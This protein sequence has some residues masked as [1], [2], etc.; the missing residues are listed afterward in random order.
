MLK[1][2]KCECERIPSVHTYLGLIAAESKR[3]KKIEL[4][5]SANKN[6]PFVQEMLNYGTNPDYKYN[7][8]LSELSE[9]EGKEI[10]SVQWTTFIKPLFD[11]LRNREITGNAAKA[12][13]E[14]MAIKYNDDTKQ[15]LLKILNKDFKLGIGRTEF[16]KVF[17]EEQMEKRQFEVALAKG[18]DPN[19]DDIF[20]GDYFLSRKLDGCVSKDSIIEFEN[21]EKKS[22]GEVV[23]KRIQGK[24]KSFDVKNGKIVFSKIK[25]Y[26]I[27]KKENSNKRWF[28]IKTK[29]GKEIK[30]TENDRLF[31][32]DGC[33]VEVSKLG[34]QDS[35]YIEN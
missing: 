16:I 5:K 15:L 25:D 2:A 10:D 21:G 7:I 12:G 6:Y 13:F 30:I 18:Y 33:W 35:I 31:S 14:I 4:L 22:I 32:S 20:C 9:G 34:I 3:D 19:K 11:R 1:S 28:K 26:M 27:I 17:G 23:E 8:H 24:I 29:S